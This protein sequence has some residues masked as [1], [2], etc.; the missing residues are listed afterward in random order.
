MGSR[1]FFAVL[2]DHALLVRLVA[3]SASA[4]ILALG[5]V[6]ACASPNLGD[7]DDVEVPLP[8]RVAPPVDDAAQDEASVADAADAADAE[9]GDA[10]AGMLH[11]FVSSAVITASLGGLAGAD[12]KCNQLAMAQGLPG[13]YRAWLSVPGTEARDRVTSAG[14]WYRVDDVVAIA[15]REELLGGSI[16]KSM[17]LD[18]KGNKAPVEEDRVWTA[19]L[20]DG[21]YSGPDCNL[22]TGMGTGRVGEAEFTDTRWSNSTV[23]D[24]GNI[25]RL[26]CFQL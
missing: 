16:S 20:P 26:Y 4:L 3:L 21:T 14:P 5:I 23:E 6:A 10:D 13:T 7:D 19:T 2:Y 12:A 17:A 24:C 18:E 22:W 25:N 11:A 8:D 1:V 9:G 15:S